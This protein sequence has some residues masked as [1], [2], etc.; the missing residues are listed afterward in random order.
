MVC[1]GKFTC[2]SCGENMQQ[3]QKQA[4]EGSRV[5]ADRARQTGDVAQLQAVVKRLEQSVAC[6]MCRTQTPS[7][8]K[9]SL[10]LTLASAKKGHAWAQ[11]SVGVKYEKGIGVAKDPKEAARWFKLAV[12]QKHPWAMSSYGFFLE[13]GIGVKKD[14]LQAKELYQEAASMGCA[15]S[16]HHLGNLLLEGAPGAGI[17]KNQKEAFCLFLLAAD[18]GF[19]NAQCSLGTCY[20]G[21]EGI[22][23]DMEKSL[24]WHTKAAE[25]GNITAMHNTGGNLLTIATE[26]YGSIEIPGKSPI[27][28]ALRW[29][30]A[31]AAKGYSDSAMVV[32]QIEE[33]MS[34]ACANCGK[35]KEQAKNGRLSRCTKCKVMQYCSKECQLQHWRAGHKIDCVGGL[36]TA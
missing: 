6:P 7:T 25:Q 8:P 5:G 1:C 15:V 10:E 21:G 4:A 28:R 16:Q 13:Q 2:P 24:Y 9:E 22:T 29:A 23:R 32:Q 19:D 3:H 12:E 17:A 30:R 33:A 35:P 36:T 26:K 14:V 34:R 20:E 18:Q 31:A 11:H 27:P